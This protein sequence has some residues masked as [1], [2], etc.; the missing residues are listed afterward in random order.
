M[1]AKKNVNQNMNMT[2]EDAVT[3]TTTAADDDNRK[4]TNIQAQKNDRM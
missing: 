4:G 3:T 2:A 1:C